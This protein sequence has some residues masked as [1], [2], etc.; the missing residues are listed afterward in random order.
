MPASFFRAVPLALLAGS[1]LALSACDVK[2]HGDNGGDASIAIG[3]DGTNV[4]NGNGQQGLSINVPGF[5]AKLNVPDLDIGDDTKI[6]DMPMFP[7][8]KVNGVNISAHEGDDAGQEN[9]GNV[10]MVFSAP[11]APAKVV[12]WYKTQAKKNG[13]EEVPATGENEFEAIKHEGD[14]G[15]T[16]FALEVSA[17]TGG[18]SGR[19]IVTGR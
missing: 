12:D 9:K 11:G 7:G 15:P 10:T 1:A 14:H 18:S 16:R 5:S 2:S 6:E 3:N 17:A 13:W 19:F 4:T 8:T